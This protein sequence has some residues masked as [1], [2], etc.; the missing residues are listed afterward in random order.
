MTPP[1]NNKAVKKPDEVGP[2]RWCITAFGGVVFAIMVL[3]VVAS[4]SKWAVYKVNQ[5]MNPESAIDQ[6][7]LS[8]VDP[9]PRNVSARITGQAGS[10]KR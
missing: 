3:M 6:R 5:V 4:L 10:D 1:N 9:F 2:V 7:A 8:A